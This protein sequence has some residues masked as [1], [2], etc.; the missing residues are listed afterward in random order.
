MTEI[1][2]AGFYTMSAVDYH[3]DP[4][5]R[6][7]LSHSVAMQLLDK[8][9]F[10]AWY[11][12]PR[13]GGHQQIETLAQD[14]GSVAHLLLTGRGRQASVIDA[15]NYRKPSARIERDAIRL[16]GQ[17][18]VLAKDF[19][20]AEEMC[21][22]A[23]QAL[24][25]MAT[26]QYAFDQKYGHCELVAICDDVSGIW[27]RCMIDFYGHQMPTGVECWDYK[28]TTGTANPVMLR[29]HMTRHGWAMQ[30]A[31]QERIISQLKPELAG[32]LHFRFL[33]QEVEPPYL[34]SVVAPTASAM[35]LA[36]KMVAAACGIWKNCLERDRWPSYPQQ[37]VEL[38]I[39]PWAEA[40]WLT[41]ELEDELVQLA[42]NDPWLNASPYMVPPAPP[43][44]SEFPPISQAGFSG[45]SPA[46]TAPPEVEARV[47]PVPPEAPIT[48]VA[49]ATQVVV[50]PVVKKSHHKKPDGAATPPA[51]RLGRPRLPVR[52]PPPGA[53][54]P[55]AL[56]SDELP[57][58]PPRKLDL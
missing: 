34:C 14:N 9:P 33:V 47:P 40:A 52:V 10:Y 46:K 35:V 45:L 29:N 30:A 42:Q 27:T 55:E 58:E 48:S 4:A 39:V 28:T 23:R 57:D 37:A 44:L 31:M 15:E 54:P 50:K 5:P 56:T 11:Y 1:T 19:K 32:R 53:L 24:S 21:R 22:T 13:L 36:H 7:A 20:T 38:A 17:T 2:G 8:N 51:R 26:G 3:G 16:R 6:P 41:R 12:N 43:V 49:P 25:S 18:P